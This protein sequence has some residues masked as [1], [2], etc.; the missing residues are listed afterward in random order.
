M[1]TETVENTSRA[2]RL[3]LCITIDENI[4]QVL[5]F[6]QQHKKQFYSWILNWFNSGASLAIRL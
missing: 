2:Q 4:T 5:P 1:W 3:R 6:M